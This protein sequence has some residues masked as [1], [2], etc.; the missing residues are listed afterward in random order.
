M[1]ASNPFSAH[2]KNQRKRDHFKETHFVRN[3]NKLELNKVTELSKKRKLGS[4]YKGVNDINLS[5]WKILLLIAILSTVILY[6]SNG[7]FEWLFTP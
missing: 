2:N 7:L 1:S 3:K 5:L 4:E 6:L